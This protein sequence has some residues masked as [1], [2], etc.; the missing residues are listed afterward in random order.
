MRVHE[1]AFDAIVNVS[2]RLEV[3]KIN[4]IRTVNAESAASIHKE[5]EYIVEHIVGRFLKCPCL[6]HRDVAYDGEEDIKEY[7]PPVLEIV[8][9]KS[10]RLRHEKGPFYVNVFGKDFM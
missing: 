8:A 4:R 2:P 1:D 5:L 3:V 6:S 9:D 10:V 7:L